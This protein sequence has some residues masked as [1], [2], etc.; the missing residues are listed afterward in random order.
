MSPV[1]EGDKKQEAKRYITKIN[2]YLLKKDVRESDAAKF[3]KVYFKYE[4]WLY[5]YL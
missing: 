3:I 1:R 5:I 4:F 2:M